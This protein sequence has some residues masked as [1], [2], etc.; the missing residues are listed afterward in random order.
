MRGASLIVVLIGSVVLGI[1]AARTAELPPGLNRDIVAR[2]CGACHDLDK[3]AATRR[4]GGDWLRLLSETPHYDMRIDPDV[5][6]KI[7]S[8]LLSAL[9]LG[10]PMDQKIFEERA[11]RLS[12]EF[13]KK[14]QEL[15][16]RQGA[17]Q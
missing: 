7:M 14:Q 13:R 5:D 10:P 16:Q 17:P 4:S 6:I 3:V 2:E 8:Y 1:G 9:S 11:R 12:E 15:L